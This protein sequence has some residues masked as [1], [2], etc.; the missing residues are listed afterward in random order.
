MLIIFYRTKFCPRCFF[1]RKY[2]AELTFGIPNLQI[3]ER[4][5]FFSPLETGKEGIHMIPALKIGEQILSSAILTRGQI[6]RFLRENG[7][8]PIDS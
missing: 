7:C 1:A 2:L 6:R 3:E 5:V 8:L 4:E